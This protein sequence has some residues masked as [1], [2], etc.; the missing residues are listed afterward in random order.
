MERKAYFVTWRSQMFMV[1]TS[2]HT[3]FSK[4]I[5]NLVFPDA[6][7]AYKEDII[8]IAL[9]P[10]FFWS[11]GFRYHLKA[12][13]KFCYSILIQSANKQIGEYSAQL[14]STKQVEIP[15]I[16]NLYAEESYIFHNPLCN[17]TSELHLPQSH[18][19]HSHIEIG[20]TKLQTYRL[21]NY[22]RK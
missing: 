5:P 4:S 6:C 9:R 13:S 17:T 2:L 20:Y 16:I 8:S 7:S 11:K 1:E 3:P 18:I 22:S 15:F 19:S 10:A 14:Y 12:L 21:I